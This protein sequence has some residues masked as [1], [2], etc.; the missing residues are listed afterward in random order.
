M[1]GTAS[2]HNNYL[3]I[4]SQFW[5]LWCLDTIVQTELLLSGLG[6]CTDRKP[7]T[8]PASEKVNCLFREAQVNA[9]D[10]GGGGGK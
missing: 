8:N 6:R 7:G 4:S 1:E 9:A 10:K 3:Q 5:I 2:F